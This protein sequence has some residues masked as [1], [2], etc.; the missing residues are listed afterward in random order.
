M[1]N[2]Q[3]R[4]GALI[5]EK[6]LD[7]L[8]NARVAVLG[9]G[10]VGSAAAEALCRAG[11]GHL[12]LVDHDT[13][14]E[15]NLNRQLLATRDAIGRAKAD[16]QL[17]RLWAINPSGDFI[18]AKEFFLPENSDFLFDWQPDYVLDAV[19][20]VTAKLF[21]AEKCVQR[22]IPLLCCLGTGNR[23]DPSL[24][25]TGELSQTAGCGCPLA[26]V[27]RRELKKRGVLQQMVVYS[28][29]PPLSV[30][31]S[32][33]QPGRHPPGSISF[34]PPAAGYLLASVAVRTLLGADALQPSR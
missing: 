20:T 1:E 27:M 33:A 23:M 15:T 14:D 16:V 8:K 7:V 10:G 17:E 5:G 31:C 28:L 6:G 25:R 2:W 21:L 13:V 26:R 22:R 30:C 32:S 12:L 19:D 34:V 9:L 3:A 11:V 4:T 18:R 29:E 24:L